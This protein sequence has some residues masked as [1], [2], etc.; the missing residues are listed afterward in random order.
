MNSLSIMFHIIFKSVFQYSGYSFASICLRMRY[1][2]NKW[3][4][5]L[6]VEFHPLSCSSIYT[7]CEMCWCCLAIMKANAG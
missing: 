6:L 4:I 7:T 1:L 3:I 2:I 5:E